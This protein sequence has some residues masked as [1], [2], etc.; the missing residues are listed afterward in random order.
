M[1]ANVVGMLRPRGAGGRGPDGPGAPRG[2]G[3]DPRSYRDRV[4]AALAAGRRFAGLHVGAGGD[5][6]RTLLVAPDGTAELI[7]TSVDDGAV[8]SIVDLVPAAT[9]D[10]REAWDRFG[11]A[12]DGHHP[13][14]PLLDHSGSVSWTVPVLGADVYQVAV[15]PI[16][17][18]VIESGHFRFHLVGDRILQVDARLFYKHRGL[19]PAAENEPF[20]VGL[21][22]AGRACA[23]CTVSNSV[24]Y[25]T[26][27]EQILGLVPTPGLARARTVLLEL[28]RVWSHLNDIAAICAG[29]GLAAGNARFADLTDR[30]RRLN[31]LL[32]GHRFAFGSVRIG[33][34]EIEAD[35]ETVDGIRDG[36]IRIQ[37]EFT[38]SWRELVFNPSFTD[39][40][41]GVGVVDAAQ[42]V[43]LG[44]TGPAARAAGLAEDVRA[45]SP[46]LSYPGFEA[47]VPTRADGDVRARFE[48]RSLELEQSFGLLLGLLDGPL[49]SALAEPGA[50]SRQIGIGLVESPRGRTSC[51][52]ERAGARAAG[53]D[54]S[55]ERSR[56]GSRDD[57]HRI[58]RWRLR[59]G[60]YANWPSVA[61]AAAGNLLPDFPLINKSF[62]LCYSCVDR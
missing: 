28:E 35:T 59:T 26:A 62:E 33:R 44:T 52:V 11:I 47:V 34:S 14:R 22:H 24:A 61:F 30:A 32:S 55:R 15:G 54:G 48:Q 60:S 36:L 23:A 4:E 3:E 5:V 20:D 1:T 25:A 37:E 57:E 21:A 53:S 40:M 2:G 41:P 56:D 51:V 6:V 29:V 17:A 38:R 58:A 49:E 31:A 46:G 13:L 50:P 12:F 7:G 8:P 43:L 10:E 27:W 16:H 39:R 19:E 42:A 18:G 9:W 45:A